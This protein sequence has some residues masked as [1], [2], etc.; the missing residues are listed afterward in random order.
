[1]SLYLLV[2]KVKADFCFLKK[3]W[4]S[5]C[6]RVALPAELTQCHALQTTVFLSLNSWDP[7]AGGRRAMSQLSTVPCPFSRG[8]IAESQDGRGW[9]GPL[10][11]IWSN[12]EYIP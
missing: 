1:L 9:K 10:E 4:F 11:I 6:L 7:G 12:K 2:L 8:G 5:P 3:T